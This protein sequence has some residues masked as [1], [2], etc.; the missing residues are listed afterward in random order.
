MLSREFIMQINALSATTLSTVILKQAT[1]QFLLTGG[2]Q[3]ELDAVYSSRAL[4]ETP[5]TSES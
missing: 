2:E 4:K 1:N 5:S 3:L